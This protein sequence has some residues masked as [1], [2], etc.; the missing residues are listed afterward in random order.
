LKLSLR[1]I[2]FY[3]HCE[4]VQ[5]NSEAN[6]TKRKLNCC[7]KFYVRNKEKYSNTW[8]INVITCSWWN[9]L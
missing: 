4:A 2:E 9:F 5:D 3:L 1:K 6:T 7:E 8:W